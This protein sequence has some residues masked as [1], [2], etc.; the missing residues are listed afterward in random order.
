MKH[1]AWYQIMGLTEQQVRQRDAIE[2]ACRYGSLTLTR[3][4]R[5]WSAYQLLKKQGKVTFHAIG[6]GRWNVRLAGAL[7]AAFIDGEDM[8]P[9][10]AAEVARMLPGAA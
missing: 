8:A 2:E 5:L 1:G 4:E 6:D 7:W 9:Y 10:A 3:K